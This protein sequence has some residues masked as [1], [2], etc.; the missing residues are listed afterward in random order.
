[1]MLLGGEV[2]DRIDIVVGDNRFKITEEDGNLC[3]QKF[4]EGEYVS[5]IEDNIKIQPVSNVKIKIL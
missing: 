2:K 5:G 4:A 1:M 3:V